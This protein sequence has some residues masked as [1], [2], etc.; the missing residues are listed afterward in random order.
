MSY[1]DPQVFRSSHCSGGFCRLCLS[2]S[3]GCDS[4]RGNCNLTR[5]LTAKGGIVTWKTMVN[6]ARLCTWSSSPTVS[7]FNAT[8]KCKTGTVPRSAV[9]EPNTSA[10]S[11][12]FTLSL[13]VRGK[14]TTVQWLKVV[15]TGRLA[16]TTSPGRLAT[17][18]SLGIKSGG[19]GAQV[20]FGVQVIDTHGPV[21]LPA[22]S[23]VFQV[24]TNYGENG[25]WWGW[26]ATTRSANQ[27]ACTL[28]LTDTGVF[29]YLTSTNCIVSEVGTE[30]GDP[31]H[32]VVDGPGKVR[33]YADRCRKYL[34]RGGLANCLTGLDVLSVCVLTD[35]KDS[36]DSRLAF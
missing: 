30:N 14:S 3:S 23:V 4:S 20:I 29:Y 16:T 28:L 19:V 18:T 9:F 34:F 6:T 2:L 22:K 7:G 21:S 17:T 13:T 12:N 31:R 8:V 15:E 24:M 5:H 33:W 1:E 27:S 32:G 36:P 11:K 26:N 10:K 25:T 35:M